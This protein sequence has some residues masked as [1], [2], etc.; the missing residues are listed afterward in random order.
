M[1]SPIG[2]R[3]EQSLLAEIQTLKSIIHNLADGV[4]VVDE[5]GKFIFFNQVA[6]SILGI[7]ATDCA[8]DAWS[9]I[10]GCYRPDGKTPYP[11]Q[12]LPLAQALTGKTICNAEIFILNSER[13]AGAWVLANASPLLDEEGKQHG[14][15]VVFCDITK[16]KEAE[17]RILTLTNAVEQTADSIVIT[18][19]NGVILYVNPAFGQTTGFS[20]EEVL[21]RTP[22]ILKSGLHDAAFYQELWDTINAGMVF[23]STIANR[24]KNGEIYFAEQTITPMRDAAG[25]ITQFVS[26]VKDV[27]EQRK[28]QEQETQMKL[29]REVQQN[30][31]RIVPPLVDRFELAGAAFP[32]DLTGGDYFDFV[33]MPERCIGICIG[34]VCGHGIG[35]ALMMA[36]LRACLRSFALTNLNA[37]TIFTLV[38][39]ALVSDLEQD[40]Y[41]TLLFCRL[42]PAK[43]TIVYASAGHVPGFVM[44]AEGGIK[45]TLSSTDIP[46]GLLPEQAFQYS[47]EFT[48][49]PG[50]ILI[51]LT[52]GVTEAERPDQSQFGIDRT[53]AFI[54]DHRDQSAREIVDG[55]FRAVREFADG[56]PQR[57]DI[58]VVLCKS[59]KQK[60]RAS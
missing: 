38:N 5:T 9:E 11:A 26:V 36:G 57:D 16:R 54:R 32:A 22:A 19:R 45:R 37:G 42:N 47:E 41:A 39:A 33:S 56:L 23:R 60:G 1:A 14:A 20:R 21:G 25:N 50:E 49:E 24:K 59:L 18:D 31:Y 43:R 34:D 29:A 46:L 58:T 35:S 6:Q 53:L 52:D 7:G 30:L 44:S 8:P 55:L 40:R 12:E 13:P 51:L 10:Y 48:L 17:T 15:V 4:I 3:S 27:T 2:K 28:L